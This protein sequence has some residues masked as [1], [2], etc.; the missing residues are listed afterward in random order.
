MELYYHEVDRSVLILSADGGLDADTAG[1][2][3]T[4]L[5]ALVRAGT[6]KLI[7]DCTNLTYISSS[8]IGV[9]VR[10]HGNLARHGGDVK[11]A[12]PPGRVLQALNLV[13]VGQLFDI[14]PDVNQARL[15]FRDP[16]GQRGES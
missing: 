4:Q 15:A 7:V 14:Y 11:V 13:R 5:E 10:L 16:S 3:L 9:L 1:E 6:T 12:S 2:L 8:G